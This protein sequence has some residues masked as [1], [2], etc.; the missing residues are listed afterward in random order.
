MNAA[1]INWLVLGPALSILI[2]AMIALL[3]GLS[4]SD[5]R[6]GVGCVFVGIGFA[7]IFY[8]SLLQMSDRSSLRTFGGRYL[9]DATASDLDW[10]IHAGLT[11]A[12]L[13]SSHYLRRADLKHPFYFSLIVL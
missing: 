12:I 13:V 4:D 5:S 8:S 9:Q 10:V 11:M 3:F 2:T 6:V 7:A 1:D